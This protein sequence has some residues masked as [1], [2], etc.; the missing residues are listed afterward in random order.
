MLKLPLV[1]KE[2]V[3][4]KERCKMVALDLVSFP[5][6]TPFG[7][8]LPTLNS[9]SS[10]EALWGPKKIGLPRSLIQISDHTFL[11][12]PHPLRLMTLVFDLDFLFAFLRRLGTGQAGFP[13]SV[14]RSS[15][16]A[17]DGA[18]RLFKLRRHRLSGYIAPVRER[19]S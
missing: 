9:S 13:S 6:P 16:S 12:I 19:G 14:F 5:I 3:V 4:N 7:T 11:V 10:A 17:L 1:N 8:D 18:S 2:R 15:S